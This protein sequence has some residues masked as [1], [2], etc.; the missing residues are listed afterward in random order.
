MRKEILLLAGLTFLKQMN[1]AAPA[2]N[3][4]KA[5]VAKAAWAMLLRGPH[6]KSKKVSLVIA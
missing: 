2:T 3:D 5:M 4:A 6:R 1:P